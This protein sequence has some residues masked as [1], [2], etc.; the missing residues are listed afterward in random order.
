MHRFSWDLHFN[1]VTVGDIMDNGDEEA[2]GAVPHRTY[3][4]VNAP[5]APPGRYTVRLTVDGKSYQQPVTLRLDPR[6][7]TTAAG[8]TQLASLSREMYDGAVSTH[9]SYLQA[10]ALVAELAK[11]SGAD[12]EAFKAQ[13]ESLAPAPARGPRSPFRRRGAAAGPPTLDGASNAL[14]AAAM[15]MQ[16]ADV[17]PT[18]TE[19]A[20]CTSARAQSRTV[21]TRWSALKGAG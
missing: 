6:V 16:G 5:W 19:I 14:L 18:A 20:A 15:A 2:T 9:A 7:K 11:V 3:P 8:L 1:P 4:S 12:V 13:V 21:L 17:A 10:R